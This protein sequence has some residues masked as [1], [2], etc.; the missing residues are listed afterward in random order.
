MFRLPLKLEAGE[1][2]A[3]VEATTLDDEAL[4][5]AFRRGEGE[6]GG[7]T[8]W[9]RARVYFPAVYDCYQWAAS[10]SRHPDGQ[11]T[12]PVGGDG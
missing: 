11:P 10:V 12:D 1:A 7:F 8:L 3:D 5:A 2:W 6:G 9:T 4:D